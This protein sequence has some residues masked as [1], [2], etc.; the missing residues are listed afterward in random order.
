MKRQH[1]WTESFG[2]LPTSSTSASPSN[3]QPLRPTSSS[4][5]VC[6]ALVF[7]VVWT[8]LAA[9]VCVCERERRV[10][11]GLSVHMHAKAKH[12]RQ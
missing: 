4:V 10:G 9:C 8:G 11:G 5:H 2:P 1:C 12:E 7:F 3:R 6:F